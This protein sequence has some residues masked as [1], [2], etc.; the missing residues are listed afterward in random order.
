LVVRAI[1][2]AR[3]NSQISHGSYTV[4]HISGLAM[5]LI[6]KIRS[7]A[8]SLPTS[9]IKTVADFII[10]GARGIQETMTYE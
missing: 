8:K 6:I 3:G 10:A 4:S 7:L 1:V 2:Q 9:I 5:K